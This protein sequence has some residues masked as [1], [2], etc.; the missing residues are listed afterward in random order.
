MLD[1][2]AQLVFGGDSLVELMMREGRKVRAVTI[3]LFGAPLAQ[4][5]LGDPAV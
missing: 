4:A 2:K 1:R 3:D 5:G